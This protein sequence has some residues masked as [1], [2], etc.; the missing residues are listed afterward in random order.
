MSTVAYVNQTGHEK[1]Y[2]NE[3]GAPTEGNSL[4]ETKFQSCR[5]S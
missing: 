1:H 2:I 4:E 5:N 3:L